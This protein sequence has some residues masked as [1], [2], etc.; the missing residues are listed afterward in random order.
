MAPLVYKRFCRMPLT[1]KVYCCSIH[2]GVS[3][4][5]LYAKPKRQDW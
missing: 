1:H 2:V 5:E 3:A 4:P